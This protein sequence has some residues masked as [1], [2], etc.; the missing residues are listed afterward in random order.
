MTKEDIK[1]DCIYWWQSHKKG[2]YN[3]LE[4]IATP[5]LFILCIP[6]IPFMIYDV[7]DPDED[8]KW[9]EEHHY[10]YPSHLDWGCHRQVKKW[11]KEY[12]K[13]EKIKAK[14]QIRRQLYERKKHNDE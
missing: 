3:I 13:N 2:I 11:R 5:F 8:M 6:F 1:I 14:E 9:C 12:E 4:D 10:V 7:G